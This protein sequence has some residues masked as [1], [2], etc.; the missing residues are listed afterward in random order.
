MN[1]Y[2]TKEWNRA[3]RWARKYIEKR[4]GLAWFDDKVAHEYMAA[5]N[6]YL[7]GHRAGRR[8]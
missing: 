2:S 7:A 1:R 3:Y 8:A 5:R 6:G 4:F